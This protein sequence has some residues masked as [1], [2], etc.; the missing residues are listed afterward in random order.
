[1]QKA[2]GIN[3]IMAQ[4]GYPVAAKELIYYPYHSLMTRISSN[5]NIF[6]GLSSFALEMSELR[7]I[8]K[9][10]NQNT[11]VIADEVCKG[12]EHKS[13]LII[14]L[15]MIELLSKVK[16]SFI[17]ATHLHDIIN[18]DRLNKLNNIKLYHLH[19]EYDEEKNLIKYDRNLKE[20]SGNNF[21]GLN[22]A[23]YLIADDKFMNLANNIK[24]DIFEL[25]DLLNCKTSNYLNFLDSTKV[26]R[27]RVKF[28]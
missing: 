21:Y 28:I 6:K 23:K 16:T 22:V 12:T 1:M 11:L 26:G 4:M 25:S 13:S 27:I 19:V 17:T 8:I 18:F 24:I 7:A 20:G 5:D 14:V 10:S 3:I 2:I 9:R 15:T